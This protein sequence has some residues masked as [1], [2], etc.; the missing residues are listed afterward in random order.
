[1]LV[2]GLTWE[3]LCITHLEF[4]YLHDVPIPGLQQNNKFQIQYRYLKSVPDSQE[5]WNSIHYN[6]KTEMQ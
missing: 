6:E 2:L 4:R 5:I 3:I 1:M